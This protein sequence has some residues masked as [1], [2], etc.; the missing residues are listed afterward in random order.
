M[1]KFF[2]CD[3]IEIRLHFHRYLST[4]WNIFGVHCTEGLF[5]GIGKR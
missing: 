5:M 4:F 1:M 3:E 2:Y